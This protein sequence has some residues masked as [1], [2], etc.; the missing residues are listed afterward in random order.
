MNE[1]CSDC[2]DHQATVLAVRKLPSGKPLCDLHWRARLGMKPSGAPVLNSVVKKLVRSVEVKPEEATMAD[3]NEVNWAN[4]QK[5]R[6]A[7]MKAKD[8][9]EKHD[10]SSCQFYYRTKKGGANRAEASGANLP[11]GANG[12]KLAGG[13]AKSRSKRPKQIPLFD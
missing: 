9:F 4:V 7:G 8:I 1:L 11:G 6:D 2:L 10:I 13:R 3:G 5:D 12:K